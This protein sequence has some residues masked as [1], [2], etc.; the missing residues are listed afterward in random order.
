MISNE[1]RERRRTMIGSSDVP[2]IMSGDGVRVAL[3]KLGEVEPA[4][5][6]DVPEVQL[7]NIVEA[8]ILDAF[9][10]RESV[11]LT[12]SP[13]TMRHAEHA[14]LGAHLDALAE[15]QVVEAKSVGWYNRRDWGEPG[16]DEVPDRVLW[17]VQQQLAV[18]RLPLAKV[19]VCFVN[20]A[21]LVALATGRAVP[22]E[23]Y[24]IPADRELEAYIVERCGKVWRH[25][26]ERTLPEPEKPIDARLIYRRDSGAIVEAD[27][28]IAA[29]HDELMLCRL[30]ARRLKDRD[31]WL[32][33]EIQAFMRDA[34]E[35]RHRGETLATWRMNKG[36]AAYTVKA[37][38]PFRVFL[39]K[40][41]AA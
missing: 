8:K 29:L 27:E 6:D 25:V 30:D 32:A 11:A 18:A 7:G 22:I 24:V 36:R 21:S 23:V 9:E 26:E 41:T 15:N 3:E 34:S 13:D 1:Q 2:R 17:Q 19:P 16:T 28:R 12:R 5:L 39:A 31:A 37:S 35:L 33:A 10:A 14:W 20:E 4:N 38:N 40:E